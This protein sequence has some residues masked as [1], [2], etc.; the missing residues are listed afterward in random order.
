MTIGRIPS[1]EGGIQPTIFDAKADIL[2]ATA[3]DTP[4]R[5]AVGA[6]GTVLTADSAETTGLKWVAP[7]GGTKNYSLLNTGGT[8]LTGAQ[9]I[10]VSGISNADSI[11]ILVIGASSASAGSTIAIRLNADAGNNYS[12]AEATITAGATYNVANFDGSE[13]ISESYFGIGT[14]ADGASGTVL[15]YCKIDGAATS[16]LKVAI[17][18]GTGRFAGGAL[19]D[20]KNHHGGGV[21]SGSAITSVSVRSFTGNF[22]AG[23][24]YVYT[25]A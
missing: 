24:V 12:H 19:D 13:G 18:G 3:A 17:Y 23:T 20:N 6:N 9:T 1:I 25:S 15:G 22:D 4:A 5:L 14:M 7:A 2:T 16:G 21:Y 8:A 11:M 10:T